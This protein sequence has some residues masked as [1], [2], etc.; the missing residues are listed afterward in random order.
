MPAALLLLALTLWAATLV[1]SVAIPPL[2][3]LEAVVQAT[4]RALGWLTGSPDVVETVVTQVRLPRVLLAAVV[5]AGLA[6]AGTAFQGVFRNPL[7]DPYLLGTASGAGLAAAIVMV[8]GRQFPWLQTWGIG[9]AAFLGAALAVLVVVILAQRGGRMP[10]VH[11]VLAG[12]VVG[13][14]L[15]ALTSLV[16]LAGRE[17][18]AG[19]LSW[20]LG[21]FS[22]ASWPR[23][24]FALPAV[25]LA[26][27]VLLACAR[28]LDLLQLGERE[29]A[30]LGLAVEAFKVVC[31]L[32]AT[33][34]TAAAV[35]SA[36]II[37]FVGL[38]VPHAVRLA[39]GPAHARLLPLA[40]VWGAI[41]LVVADLLARGVAGQVELPVG[42]VTAVLGAPAFLWLLRRS[43]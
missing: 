19:V 32:A 8:F 34:A 4:A 24:A 29:A 26:T 14:L 35:A 42:M 33:L 13:S 12:V 3:V 39:A 25:L 5:G 11:L 22:F 36:G 38:L 21:S 43:A 18:A 2:Q 28:A 40:A 20:L 41:F 1:G 17:Q 37:G 30:Q 31:L 16:M 7:A 23:L 27:A 9:P 6:A 10:I 15:A